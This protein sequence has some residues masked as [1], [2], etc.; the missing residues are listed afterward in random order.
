MH[1]ANRRPNILWICTDQQRYDTLGCYGNPFVHTPH[2]DALAKS[3]VQFEYAYSQ[4]PVCTPARSCMLTGRYPRTNRCR[5]NGQKI[6]AEEVLV[7]R[8]FAD[9]GYN[10]GLSGKLHIAPCQAG[11]CPTT[12]ERINDGYAAFHWSHHPQDFNRPG[13]GWAN[14]E[15][16]VWLRRHGQSFHTSPFEDSAI[17][18]E[19]MPEE[20][21]QT[22]WCT[23]RAIDFIA[24]NQAYQQPWF[25]SV[26]YYD[27]HHPFDPPKAY[28]ERYLDTLENIPLPAY[29]PGEEDTKSLFVKR[30]FENGGYNND[31]RFLRKNMTPRDHRLV[32]AAYWAMVDLIDHQVGRLIDMLEQTGQRE[33]TLILFHSDH[34]ELLG[35]HGL[36]MKGPH[37]YDCS[38]RIPLLISWPGHVVQSVHSKGLVELTD[39][40]PTL[41][42]AAGLPLWPG[43]Q[44]ESLW[45]LLSGKQ[46]PNRHRADVMSEYLNAMPTHQEPAAFQTM[47]REERYKLVCRHD[48]EEGELYDMLE[49]PREE[50]NLWHDS[51]YAG[52]RMR[53]IK[54]L[55]DRIAFSVDPLPPRM[56]G[57]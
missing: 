21:H 33:N 12:E 5:Q 49:D 40:A 28:L 22:K 23:D 27:P 29:M 14:N 44:G 16:H 50:R 10:C 8:L 51:A 35:D 32:R 54:R 3:G 43:M 11:V 48:V 9:H 26:N 38:V 20:W 19:G 57:Y 34:G 46:D 39:I 52:V 41:L 36:Y 56:A 31:K 53:L 47:L 18:E 15:Y 17:V 24:A 7:S 4:S 6:P 42:E 25:F 2:L 1:T 55:C 45:P 37:F 30:E 13:S